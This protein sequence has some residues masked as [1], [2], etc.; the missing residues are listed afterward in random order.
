[1]RHI[2]LISLTVTVLLILTGCSQTQSEALFDG[3]SLD[4]WTMYLKNPDVD[5][6]TVWSIE[7]GV[8]HCKGTPNGY[9][10]TVGEYENYALHLEWRWVDRPTN[11]GVLLHTTGEDKI[12]PLCVEAQLKHQNAG[13]FVTIQ[14]GSAITVNGERHQPAANKI[15]HLIPKQHDSSEKPA[16][17][18]NSYG[19]V[20]KDGSITLTVNGVLQN[21]ATKSTLTRGAICLQSEGSPIEFRNISITILK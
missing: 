8:I 15:Y 19:I 16:G 21:T 18:W 11:S 3:E 9:I 13:D 5:P 17:Q 4:G 1:M 2:G 7:N 6:S 12:W 20:C 10:K 14:K